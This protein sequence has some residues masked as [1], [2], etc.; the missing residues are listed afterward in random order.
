MQLGIYD[1]KICSCYDN[2][3]IFVVNYFGFF[4]FYCLICVVV[5]CNL[6]YFI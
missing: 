3:G 4:G 1:N 6:F 5:D 2:M